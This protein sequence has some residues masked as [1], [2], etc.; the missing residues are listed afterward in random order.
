LIAEGPNGNGSMVKAFYQSKIALKWKDRGV[1]FVNVVLID[2]ALADP[3]DAELLGFTAHRQLTA[4]I[5]AIEKKSPD[6]PLGV[7]GTDGIQPFLI[8][9]TDLLEEEKTLQNPDGTLLW[10]IANLSLFCF[11]L[12]FLLE[13]GSNSSLELPWHLAYKKSVW[14]FETFLFD[15]LLWAKKWDVLLFPR[16]LCYAPLKTK[17]DLQII[18]NIL[19]KRR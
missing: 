4:G 12:S 18:R 9:Y 14:K 13:M 2:N 10:R 3:F 8:E 15:I 16:D 7:I 19:E 6:E 1:D 5:K 17:E 11:S